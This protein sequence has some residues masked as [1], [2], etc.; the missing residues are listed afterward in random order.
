MRI[1]MIAAAAENGVIGREGK[2]PWHLSDDLRRFKQLTMGHTIVLGRRTWESIGRP[3]PGRRMIVVSR[4]PDFRPGVDGVQTAAS[5]DSALEI[6][7]DSGEDEVFIIGGAELYRG[8][9]PRADRM[10]YT[11]VHANVEG[12]TF[13]PPVKWGEWQALELRHFDAD[14]NNEYAHDQIVFQRRE[15]I[16][17]DVIL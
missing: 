5:L 16:R 4:R 6:A 8:A 11:R 3:L 10:Y 15:L 13:F 1:S 12:D 7:Q 9:L 2:L 17:E 14:C